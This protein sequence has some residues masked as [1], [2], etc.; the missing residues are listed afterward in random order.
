MGA[1][2]K[3]WEQLRDLFNSMTPA[4]RI[5]SVLLLAVIVIS[6]GYLFTFESSG[7]G[8]Y[9]LGGQDFNPVEMG[10][11][12]AAFGKAGLNGATIEG[13]RIKIPAGEEAKYVAAMAAEGALP[14]DF[15]ESMTR[16]MSE[17]SPFAS[18]PEK[19]Q[20]SSTGKQR[21]LT[22]V[23]KHMYKEVDTAYVGYSEEKASGI[24]RNNKRTAAVEINTFNQNAGLEPYQ[25]EAIRN[26]VAASYAGL[27]KQDISINV[28]GRPHV[29]ANDP[30]DGTQGGMERYFAQQKLQQ[31]QFE[32][33]IYSM[34][35]HYVQGVTVRTFVDLDPTVFERTQSRVLDNKN[36]GTLSQ[37][38][39][40][41]T[42]SSSST[43]A[44][45]R[46][47]AQAQGGSNQP[48]ALLNGEAGNSDETTSNTSETSSIPGHTDKL[49]EQAG[50]QIK[51]VSASIGVPSSYFIGLWK[52]ANPDAGREPAP[53]DWQPIEQA[54][55]LEWKKLVQ[56]QLPAQT[57][58]GSPPEVAFVTFDTLSAPAMPEE[59]F[60][61]TAMSWL[62]AYGGTLGMVFLGFVGLMMVRSF[63]KSAS[64]PAATPAS[65]DKDDDDAEP[66][67]AGTTA[68]KPARKWETS[69]TSV[70]DELADLVRED[71]DTAAAILQGWISSAT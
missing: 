53:T 39:S 70:K 8:A 20:A 56:A 16:A 57:A 69:G 4:A 38:T 59:E 22:N 68:A 35:A 28:N 50:F 51:S 17:I 3:T 24:G 14:G 71:P 41:S 61:E 36:A 44:G 18:R 45:G 29:F 12:Q 47:P 5:M 46:P 32:D 30:T 9:L 55:F 25:A 48:L 52:Q 60:T 63:V 58:A 2:N 42:Q 1:L 26:L 67:I 19:E 40:E 33:K 49:S 6:L 54:K 21:M 27:Q 37:S 11:I 23:V 15:H 43:P 64:K 65:E 7:Q 31:Q 62:S 13:T 10:R 66:A 34:L